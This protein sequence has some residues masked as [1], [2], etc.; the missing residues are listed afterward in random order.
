MGVMLSL[1]RHRPDKGRR[2]QGQH[3]R[4]PDDQ[5]RGRALAAVRRADAPARGRLLARLARRVMVRRSPPAAEVRPQE[6]TW[7]GGSRPHLGLSANG[8]PG[9]AWDEGEHTAG[10]AAGPGGRGAQAPAAR[11]PAA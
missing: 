2:R 7:P 8:Q 5:A 11:A 9:E 6:Q 1:D 3:A 4:H 10:Q